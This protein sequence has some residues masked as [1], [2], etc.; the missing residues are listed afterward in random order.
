MPNFPVSILLFV[1]DGAFCLTFARPSDEQKCIFD[2]FT[3]S[4]GIQNLDLL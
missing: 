4:S 3:Y 2:I 1:L